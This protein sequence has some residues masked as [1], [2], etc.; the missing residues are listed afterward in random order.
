MI[1]DI[2]FQI[3]LF[4][5]IALVFYYFMIEVDNFKKD[6]I[7]NHY[8]IKKALSDRCLELDKVAYL[9]R[10]LS[11]NTKRSI[12]SKPSKKSRYKLIKKN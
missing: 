6:R 8:N 5:L 2:L 9:N 11:K 4:L 7:K 3:I 10:H 12:K 1:F